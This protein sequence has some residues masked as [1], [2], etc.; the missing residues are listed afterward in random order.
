MESTSQQQ[1]HDDQK[2]SDRSLSK[3]LTVAALAASLGVSL[4]VPVGDALAD[5]KR[6]ESP[7]T[8]YS[9]QDKD[10][11][12]SEQMKFS[13]QTKTSVQGKIAPS[14][15]IKTEGPMQQNLYGR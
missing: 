9:R 7:P 4:G 8:A 1:P 15:Q 11:V 5:N 13:T 12:A 2:S 10:S 6:M 14:S 3:T